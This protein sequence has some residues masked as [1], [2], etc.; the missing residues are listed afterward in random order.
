MDFREHYRKN[1]VPVAQL[2][3]K[4]RPV[5][6][7]TDV[8]VMENYSVPHYKPKNFSDKFALQLT[9]F[10]GKIV[11]LFFR[12]KYTHHAVVL[13][14]VAAVPGMIGG[15]MRHF[16]SLRR[17]TRDHGW[18]GELLEESENER[19]H[20][21]TFM[22]LIQPT[23]FERI[24]VLL[25][26]VFFVPFYSFLYLVTPRTCH[27]LVGYLEEEAVAAYTEYLKAIDD[28]DIQNVA[29]PEIAINYWNLD[30]DNSTLRDVI[31]CIRG[32]EC[33][34]SEINHHYGSKYQH[35]QY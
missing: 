30:P 28:G 26:Q 6:P 24:L 9:L 18:I 16:T 25:A 13:E 14:T 20:L 29:A 17:M 34:H 27:R 22:Q 2:D 7:Y 8:S 12:D 11:H 10:L 4:K 3:R 5:K 21:L 33:M 32:D 1:H 35:G 31:L 19:M 23:F 15:M